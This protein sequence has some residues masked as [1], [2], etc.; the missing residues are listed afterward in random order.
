[1]NDPTPLAS[2]DQQVLITRIWTNP[3][4]WRRGTARALRHAARADP[5]RPARRRATRRCRRIPLQSSAAWPMLTDPRAREL[6]PQPR[7]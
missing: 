1:M 3:T 6:L 4:R 5:H 7:R 2:A